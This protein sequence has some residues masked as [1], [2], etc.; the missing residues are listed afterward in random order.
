MGILKPENLP[1]SSY[2]GDFTE[3]VV[4]LQPEGVI[5]KTGYLEISPFRDLSDFGVFEA[6]NSRKV[7][8]KFRKKLNVF[9]KS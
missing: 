7:P 1:L 8:R 6:S 5:L 4:F 9:E 2:F 3:H